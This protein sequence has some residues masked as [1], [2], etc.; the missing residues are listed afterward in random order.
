MFSRYYELLF[1][2]IIVVS[3]SNELKKIIQTVKSGDINIMLY[4]VDS[5]AF[6]EAAEVQIYDNSKRLIETLNLRGEDSFPIIDSIISDTIF[7]SYIL[8]IQKDIL[9]FEDVV[10][11]DGLIDKDKLKYVYVFKNSN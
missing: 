10:L 3:C 7:M 1:I 4:N 6:G 8:P 2:I 5:G 11:G 9:S